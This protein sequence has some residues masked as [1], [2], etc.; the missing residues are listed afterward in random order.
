MLKRGEFYVELDLPVTRN[1]LLVLVGM[2]NREAAGEFGC[3]D[4]LHRGNDCDEEYS[5]KDWPNC[6]HEE[7]GFMAHLNGFPFKRIPRPCREKHFSMAISFLD[8][9]TMPFHFFRDEYEESKIPHALLRL[10]RSQGRFGEIRL[11]ER[12]QKRVAAALAAWEAVNP[13]EDET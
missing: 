2:A 9:H 12:N 1:D 5:T 3:N 7:A 8:C 10:G 4:C 11:N 13:K 6:D